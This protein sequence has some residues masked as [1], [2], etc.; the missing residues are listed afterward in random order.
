MDNPSKQL[1]TARAA[2]QALQDGLPRYHSLVTDNRANEAQLQKDFREGSGKFTDLTAAK[3]ASAT[4]QELLEQH[5]SDIEAARA[6]VQRLEAEVEHLERHRKLVKV[7]QEANK[8]EAAFFKEAEELNKLLLE[9]CEAL[10]Q[11]QRALRAAR[12][13]FSDTLRA[14]GFKVTGVRATP[15]QMWELTDFLEKLGQ[16]VS[17]NAVKGGAI[18]GRETA[19]WHNA[20]TK[21]MPRPFGEHVINLLAA[22]NHITE[23]RLREER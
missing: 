2:L 15:E 20:N 13:T 21:P 16:E 3:T 22:Y 5:Q 12:G 19:D 1:E 9:R 17:L 18:R 11:H 10:E 23:K 7:A 4:A 6:E 8:E 14:L